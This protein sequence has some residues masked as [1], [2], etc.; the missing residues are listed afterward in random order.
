MVYQEN[1]QQ[2]NLPFSRGSGLS[3]F[4]AFARNRVEPS[5]P[6][7][8]RFNVELYGSILSTILGKL[9]ELMVPCWMITT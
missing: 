9:E 5:L 4:D 2:Q 8:G 7:R 6:R 3:S 1:L